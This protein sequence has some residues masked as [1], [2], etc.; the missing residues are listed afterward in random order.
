MVQLNGTLWETQ[1]RETIEHRNIKPR[2]YCSIA[3]IMERPRTGKTMIEQNWLCFSDR[4]YSS[5][6]IKERKRRVTKQTW[7][8]KGTQI[9]VGQLLTSIYCNVSPS[10]TH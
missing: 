9:M 6:Q 8:V 5:L 2:G 10:V 7:D 4:L 3:E 1:L